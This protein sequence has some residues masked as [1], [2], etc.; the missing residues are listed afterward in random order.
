MPLENHKRIRQCA[1]GIMLY[2]ERYQTLPTPSL[3]PVLIPVVRTPRNTPL[4]PPRLHIPQYQKPRRIRFVILDVLSRRDQAVMF[5]CEFTRDGS[6][7]DSGF[8]GN[9]FCSFGCR[10]DVL[11]FDALEVFRQEGLAL[12]PGLRVGVEFR[13]VCVGVIGL[14]V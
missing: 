8:L 3:H 7:V 6:G 5:T 4:R 9:K 10:G 14:G 13:D 12:A 11:S 1:G 2:Q